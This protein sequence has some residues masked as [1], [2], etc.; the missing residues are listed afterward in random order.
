MIPAPNEKSA[1]ARAIVQPL[2]LSPGDRMHDV[3]LDRA[4]DPIIDRIPQ[5]RGNR[6]VR[7]VLAILDQLN[8]EGSTR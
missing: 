5:R 3:A 8:R 1:S 6:Q 7:T 2:T 4:A